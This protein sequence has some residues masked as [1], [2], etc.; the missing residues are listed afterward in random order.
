VYFGMNSGAVWRLNEAT[1]SWACWQTPG[2]VTSLALA[3]PGQ[4]AVGVGCGS[5]GASVYQINEITGQ[6]TKAAI[7][8]G[9]VLE[10]KV[11]GTP[12]GVLAFDTYHGNVFLSTDGGL[13]YHE[14]SSPGAQAVYTSFVASN[15]AIYMG[16]EGV[17]ASNAA[18]PLVSYDGGRTWQAAG[19]DF[20]DSH[21]NLTALGQA[22]NGDILVGRQSLLGAPVMRISASGVVTSSSVG[23]P[24]YSFA[25]SFAAVGNNTL[26]VSLA[27]ANVTEPPMISYN[28][29]L[30]WQSI[31][32]LPANADRGGF[33]VTSNSVYYY[34]AAGLY[35]AVR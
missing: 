5:G 18:A 8:D 15:G 29:G 16:G 27:R 2:L 11:Q 12:G 21:G 31:P 10:W 23:L 24:L 19:V 22:N 3:G 6:V 26:L 32:S 9:K 34:D 7:S 1:G 14:I 25:E 20:S 33:A 17:A 30:T 28:D 13:S 35:Q 4:L